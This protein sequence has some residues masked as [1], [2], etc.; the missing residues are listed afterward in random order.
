[1]F[2]FSATGTPLR[3]AINSGPDL[4]T[5]LHPFLFTDKLNWPAGVGEYGR[6]LLVAHAA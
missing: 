2:R 5:P 4:T 1:M 3:V 6:N